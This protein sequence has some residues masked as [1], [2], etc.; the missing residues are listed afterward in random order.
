MKLASVDTSTFTE[1]VALIDGQT[2]RGE[3]NIR[4]AYGHAGNCAGS[5]QSHHRQRA[6]SKGD[7]HEAVQAHARRPPALAAAIDSRPAPS[8]TPPAQVATSPQLPTLASLAPDI[9]E[10]IVVPLI[11]TSGYGSPRRSLP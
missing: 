7:E 4:R 8:L 2:L 6:T 11:A 1:S 10:V 5:D 3:R 9:L